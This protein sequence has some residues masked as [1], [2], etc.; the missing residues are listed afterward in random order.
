MLSGGAQTPAV[1]YVKISTHIQNVKLKRN[2]IGMGHS[3]LKWVGHFTVFGR[4]AREILVFKR[5]SFA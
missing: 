2:E 3:W 4:Y 1:H 5:V